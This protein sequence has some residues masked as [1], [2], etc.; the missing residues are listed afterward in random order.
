MHWRRPDGVAARPRR[1]APPFHLSQPGRARRPGESGDPAEWDRGRVRDAATWN[2][3]ASSHPTG[4]AAPAPQALPRRPAWRRRRPRGLVAPWAAPLA[5]VMSRGGSLKRPPSPASDRHGRP[6]PPAAPS[7]RGEVQ[8]RRRD[9]A[10]RP[11]QAASL[12]RSRSAVATSQG[13]EVGRRQAHPASTTARWP[14]PRRT[15]S[16][17][18]PRVPRAR[19]HRAG[20]PAGR[21][22]APHRWP[23]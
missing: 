20:L 2:R 15:P 7:A 12:T 19:W 23:G 5:G 8:Q 14:S 3:P 10:G 17:A 6:A 4:C 22:E 21:S 13:G 9:G 18:R 16:P 11:S 1:A